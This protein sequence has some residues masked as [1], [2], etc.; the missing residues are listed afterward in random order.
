MSDQVRAYQQAVARLNE[1]RSR[2]Q[3]IVSVIEAARAALTRDSWMKVRVENIGIGWPPE[4]A[5]GQGSHQIDGH[6]WPDAQRLA[7]TLKEYHEAMVSVRDIY[8][9]IPDELRAV[10]TPPPQR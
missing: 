3:E 4:V 8:D 7:K 1:A 2:M 10:M 6:K 5:Y 9:R